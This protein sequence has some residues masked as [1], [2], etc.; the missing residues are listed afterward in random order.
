MA[1][2]GVVM[3]R[4]GV[5]RGL[6]IRSSAAPVWWRASVTRSKFARTRARHHVHA[7]LTVSLG[8]S[9]VIA[10]AAIVLPDG[11]ALGGAGWVCDGRFGQVCAPLVIGLMPAFAVN[12][13]RVLTVHGRCAR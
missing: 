9:G 7:G 5:V 4:F 10:L 1:I 2:A 8:S 11:D 12:P 13:L 6:A 3:Q